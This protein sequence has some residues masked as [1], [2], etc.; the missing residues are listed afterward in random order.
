MSATPL[1]VQQAHAGCSAKRAAAPRFADAR[2]L[3]QMAG[4]LL[5]C[6]P[7]LVG[8]EGPGDRFIQSPALRSC[9]PPPGTGRIREPFQYLRQDG[10][11][12]FP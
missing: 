5:V 8:F 12:L 10:L 4:R 9:A 1:P 6:R 3:A 11:G 2:Q 7:Q